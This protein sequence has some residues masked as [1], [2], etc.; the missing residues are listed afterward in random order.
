MLL[1]WIEGEGRGVGHPRDPGS[2]V[3][4]MSKVECSSDLSSLVFLY[5]RELRPRESKYTRKDLSLTPGSATC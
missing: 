1:E 5:T 3:I 4:V 2:C